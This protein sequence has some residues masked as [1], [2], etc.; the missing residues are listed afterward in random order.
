MVIGFGSMCRERGKECLIF[1]T[2][3]ICAEIVV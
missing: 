1:G 3:P 2:S